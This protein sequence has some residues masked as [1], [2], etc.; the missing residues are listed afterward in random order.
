MAPILPE[1]S[2]RLRAAFGVTGP[3]DFAREAEFGFLPSGH[4]LGGPPNLFPRVEA[5]SIPGAQAPG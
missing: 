2:E 3:F 1:K 5:A 4:A